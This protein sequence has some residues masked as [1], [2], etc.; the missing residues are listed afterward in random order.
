M[1]N[2]LLKHE[3]PFLT[4]DGIS[5]SN[6]F[7]QWLQ[8]KGIDGYEG[9]SFTI[10]TDLL[11]QYLMQNA[12]IANF[13]MN[14]SNVFRSTIWANKASLSSRMGYTPYRKKCAKTQ[15][16]IEI[17][18]DSQVT[19][20]KKDLV[21]TGL[22]NGQLYKF[23]LPENVSNI[24]SSASTKYITT[25]LYQGEWTY[26]SYNVDDVGFSEFK[27]H[28]KS[29]DISTLKVY[30]Y[31]SNRN[32][33]YIEYQR[34]NEY[35][36]INDPLYYLS[37]D[38]EGFYNLSFG[39]YK[40]GH[41][42]TMG[43]R[44]YIEYISTEGINGNDCTH[45]STT[46][47]YQGMPIKIKNYSVPSG[48]DDLESLE[49]INLNNLFNSKATATDLK[50]RR[51]ITSRFGTI[52]MNI[53]D[54]DTLPTPVYGVIYVIVP[55]NQDTAL[56][57]QFLNDHKVSSGIVKVIE[58]KDVLVKPMVY[59]YNQSNKTNT[60]YVE[61][62]NNKISEYNHQYSRIDQGF[63]PSEFSKFI[64]HTGVLIINI[65]YEY[66]LRLD[67]VEFIPNL[68]YSQYLNVPFTV[69][70]VKYGDATIPVLNN[71]FD[72]QYNGQ[73]YFTI[74]QSDDV[75]FIDQKSHF[76]PIVDTCVVKF[77]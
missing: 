30:V 48:G 8:E 7:K 62:I 67:P 4:L 25:T 73:H 19:L 54:G 26:Y 2:S 64:D 66:T 24:F 23:V 71:K 22:K 33:H 27:I 43:S 11:G 55:S 72:Y 36:L 28:D 1:K 5:I 32:D 38:S 12:F 56:I 18:S 45:I 39:D 63:Y 60:E 14:E 37:I 9:S 40:L 10:V 52:E 21:F 68:T 35:S 29:I 70:Q 3:T 65:D 58:A 50:Y 75:M 17:Q 34:I 69:S 20:F 57:Q 53:L 16:E 42:P 77:K 41:R 13:A 51:L 61:W 44:I 49:S 76:K 31:P 6:S 59:V 46:D 47:T 74:V 15:V